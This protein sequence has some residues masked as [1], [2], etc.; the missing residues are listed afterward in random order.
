MILG[1]GEEKTG[2]RRKQALLADTCEALI[3]GDLPRRRP[4]AGA[5]SSSCASWATAIEDARQPDYFG[6]D[7]KS[8]LQ[9]AAAGAWAGRCRT[10][11]SP[12]KSA[13]TT[14]R[15]FTSKCC[16]G[17]EVIAQ[18]VGRTKKDAEQEGAKTGACRHSER[19]SNDNDNDRIACA[20][21][22]TLFNFDPPATD[23]EVRA[24]S[25]Q[26]V[27]KLS[28]STR[29]RRQRGAF[30]ARSTSRGVARRLIDDLDTTRRRRIG[31]RSREAKARAAERSARAAPAT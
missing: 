30:N 11:A 22:Q 27:R 24:A 26:F 1:R 5:R 16:V 3:A 18:G 2:G 29:R 28:G 9:E 7:H 19:R 14:A 10:T 6:R 12:A 23:E 17:G 15:C 31:R 13:P 8:R 25:L 20:K 21:H 4:R